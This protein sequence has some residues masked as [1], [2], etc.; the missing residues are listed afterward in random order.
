MKIV[1]NG[2]YK[3]GSTFVYSVVLEI[4]RVAKI[5]YLN[6]VVDGSEIIDLNDRFHWII[7]SHNWIPPTDGDIKTIYT[8]RDYLDVYASFEKIEKYEKR[9]IDIIDNLILE[10]SRRRE[11]LDRPSLTIDYEDLF[12]NELWVV[13]QINSYLNRM[14]SE[15]QEILIANKLSRKNLKYITDKALFEDETPWH[16]HHISDDPSPGNYIDVLDSETI[17][18]VVR[19]CRS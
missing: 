4:F 12:D 5:T 2:G 3:T 1:C 10:K 15:T 17:E 19:A 16:S 13:K 8:R 7:K 18:R 9:D 14:V 11:M 6:A